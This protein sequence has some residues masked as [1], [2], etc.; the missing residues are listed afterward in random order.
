MLSVIDAP[1]LIQD[2]SGRLAFECSYHVAQ[3]YSRRVAQQEVDKV[4]VT[5]N[6]SDFAVAFGGQL[7][8][9]LAQKVS[10]LSGEC[11][12]AKFRTKDNVSR[13]VIDAV[14]CCVKV[15]IPDTLAHG[16]DKLLGR[17]AVAVQRM[18]AH[19]D[20]SSSKYYS[21]LVPCVVSKSLITKYQKN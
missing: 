18:L 19:R 10:P 3:H 13:Q 12:M 11:R 16:L 6:L 2:L 17:C 20:W 8:Q 7:P 21:D 5:V 9:D 15:K 14:A 1:K 4:D